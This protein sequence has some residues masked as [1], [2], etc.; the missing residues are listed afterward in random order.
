MGTVQKIATTAKRKIGE[1]RLH[2][3]TSNRYLPPQKNVFVSFFLPQIYFII[4][5]ASM[6]A[7]DPTT[8]PAII[9]TVGFTVFLPAP[10]WGAP[11]SGLGS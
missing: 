9:M 10:I 3:T 1:R 4:D 8:T 6:V 7:V 2:Y 5:L 11:L